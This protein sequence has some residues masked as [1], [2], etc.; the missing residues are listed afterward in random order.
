MDALSFV[1]GVGSKEL[2]GA[3]LKVARHTAARA[4]GCAAGR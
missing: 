2:R 3:Q 4:P 1:L